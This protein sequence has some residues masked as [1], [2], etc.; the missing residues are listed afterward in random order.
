MNRRMWALVAL[1]MSAVQAVGCS[2]DSAR[3][4]PAREATALAVRLAEIERGP[5]LRP[6]Q[7]AGLLG[8]GSAVTLSFKV[9]GVV[10]R[11]LVREGERVRR[12]QPLAAID[13]TELEA[14]LSQ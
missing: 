1:L 3:A 9:G 8:D 14:G 4:E 7:A 11:V 13:P 5:V 2:T 6:V 12:G 10:T